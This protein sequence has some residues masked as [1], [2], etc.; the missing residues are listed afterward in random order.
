MH[1]QLHGSFVYAWA[2][3]HDTFFGN[4]SM[5]NFVFRCAGARVD[6][7][8]LYGVHCVSVSALKASLAK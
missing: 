5:T 7:P 6:W 4:W 2:V 1:S 3:L 8:V